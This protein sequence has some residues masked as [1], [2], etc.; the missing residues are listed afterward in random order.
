MMPEQFEKMKK[1]AASAD[2]KVVSVTCLDGDILEGFI[3]FVDDECRDTI[4]Q[5][6]RS[7]NPGRYKMENAYAIL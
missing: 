7:N 5:P 3:R 2:A 1:A 4:F 6:I